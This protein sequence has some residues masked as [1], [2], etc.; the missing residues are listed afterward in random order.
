MVTFYVMPLVTLHLNLMEGC[1][2]LDTIVTYVEESSLPFVLARQHRL[3]LCGCVC[4]VEDDD[5]RRFNWLECGC[6]MEL[7][8]YAST[9]GV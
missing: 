9:L 2:T 3:F 6:C 8:M 7:M 4:G 1:E 5:I